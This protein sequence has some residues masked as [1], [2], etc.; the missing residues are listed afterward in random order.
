MT[1]QMGRFD[2]R[3]VDGRAEP[4]ERPNPAFPRGVDIDATDG[5][6]PACTIPL[7]YP[8]KRIGGYLVTCHVCGLKAVCTTAGRADDPKS[9]RVMCK[10]VATA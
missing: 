6:S 9:M 2:V 7:P 8:A 4:K 3:W 10:R 5:A 1:K